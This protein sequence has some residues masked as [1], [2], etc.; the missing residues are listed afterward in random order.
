MTLRV[1]TKKL[2]LLYLLSWGK[3]FSRPSGNLLGDLIPVQKY[4]D[5][6][7]Q[8]RL[9]DLGL[10]SLLFSV[11][12]RY[13]CGFG[14]ATRSLTSHF[15]ARAAFWDAYME[16]LRPC[17]Y[18]HIRAELAIVEELSFVFL[19]SYC[20]HAHTGVED[21]RCCRRHAPLVGWLL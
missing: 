18:V 8:P 12:A 19:F 10:F 15:P 4:F 7:A 6:H 1:A 16:L 20:L 5:L 2:Q 17:L 14:R 9:R 21:V 3:S 11:D 13:R